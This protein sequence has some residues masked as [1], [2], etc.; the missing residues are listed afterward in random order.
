MEKESNLERGFWDLMGYAAQQQT[1]ELNFTAKDKNDANEKFNRFINL[2]TKF[3]ILNKEQPELIDN[4]NG[5]YSIKINNLTVDQARKSYELNSI[6]MSYGV[7]RDAQ[8]QIP[9][10]EYLLPKPKS[11]KIIE[12]SDNQSMT[13]KIK[14]SVTTIPAHPHFDT[15]NKIYK[16]YGRNADFCELSNPSAVDKIKKTI[17]VSVKPKPQK[18]WENPVY[19]NPDLAA[20]IAYQLGKP[21]T[22]T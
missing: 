18:E 14:K 20:V 17:E 5:S 21:Y 22:R 4:T 12:T 19:E 16:I 10:N 6:M 11:K 2:T 15:V 7:Y 9:Y 1:R 8:R 3:G 13:S